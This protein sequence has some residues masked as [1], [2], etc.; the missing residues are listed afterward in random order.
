[1]CRHSYTA[2][3]LHYGQLQLPRLPKLVELLLLLLYDYIDF[4]CSSMLLRLR[5]ITFYDYH[6][7]DIAAS[8]FA[9]K[10][11]VLEDIA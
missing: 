7:I 3:L 10:L 4:T 9:A 2:D 1:M 8:P 5:V 6:I 11:L